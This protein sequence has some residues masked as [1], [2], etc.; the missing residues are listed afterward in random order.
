M[1]T[2]N[3]ENDT[4]KAAHKNGRKTTSVGSE[5][6]A[7]AERHLVR[8]GLRI[9]ERNFR[10]RFGEI[11]LIARDGATLIFIEVRYRRYHQFGGAGTSVDFRKQRKLLATANGYLQY[12][13]IDCPCR[14]DVITIEPAPNSKTLSVDW[15]Q[16]AFGQ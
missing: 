1:D 6:E 12:R 13:K 7:L 2:K 10:G 4:H 16:N 15:I 8:A 11:D 14:F 3:I 5:M 9:V